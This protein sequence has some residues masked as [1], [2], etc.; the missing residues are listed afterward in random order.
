MK[1]FF[2]L[3]TFLLIS[4]QSSQLFAQNKIKWLSWEEA[5]EK[6]K[7]DKKKIF[8]DVYTDWCGWCK[9]M[10]K[11]TF[12]EDHIARYVNAN[13]YAVKFD[14]EM[15]IPV[16]LKGK[17]YNFVKSGTSGYHEF[18]AHILQGKM[19]YPSMVFMDEDVSMIQAIPGYQDSPTFEM[20]I[21]YFGSNS[22]KSIP[23]NK[24]MNLFV[25]D[26]YFISPMPGKN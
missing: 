15:K 25:R 2:Y 8:I 6:S 23:W 14:A 3:L 12:S 18:A 4:L 19:S 11:T 10:D 26:Q 24:Y 13:Y 7:K 9:K 16:T 22:H 17:T 1:K 20:I 5:L 21:T